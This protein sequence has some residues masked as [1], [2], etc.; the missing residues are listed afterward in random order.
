MPRPPRL[1]VAGGHYHVILRGNH[2]EAL[3]DV[4]DDRLALND[5]VAET[6]DRQRARWHAF[7]WMTN[8]LHAL[9][10]VGELPLGGLMQRVAQRY[11]RYRHRRLGTA[12]H[13]FERRYK[14]WL[15]D[16]DAYFTTLLR[17][18]HLNPVRARMVRHADQYPWSSHRAYL[19]ELSLPW[20]TTD[21]GLSLFG[22]TPGAARAGYRRF[23]AQEATA[24]EDHLLRD[25]HPEDSRVFGSD[26]FIASI[27]LTPFKPRSMLT[28][29][30]VAE[31]LCAES[32]IAIETVRSS[33]RQRSLTK[34]R[35]A[36][37]R[38]AVDERIASLREVSE[39]LGRDPASL[40]ELLA[41]HRR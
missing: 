8:H 34:I 40:S 30:A 11:S 38:R 27:A 15:V 20:L 13:L 9:I 10:Q 19:G 33:S 28:L 17:Y 35:V 21:F 26:R 2:R 23:M 6:L 41:R 29:S 1:H 12:G 36:I 18:I 16:V 14:A 37:A 7:C 5:I 4:A 22:A 31:L 32:G 24:S 3:F 39:F 25:T